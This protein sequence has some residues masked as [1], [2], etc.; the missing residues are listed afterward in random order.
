VGGLYHIFSF[1]IGKDEGYLFEE[2]HLFGGKILIIETSFGLNFLE[3][4][5][6]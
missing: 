3:P 6:G 2:P 5:L 4:L 1:G